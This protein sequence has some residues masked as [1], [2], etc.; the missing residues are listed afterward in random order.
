[1]IVYLITNKKTGKK[2]VGQTIK[3]LKRRWSL[4]LS[5]ATRGSAMYLHRAIRKYGEENFSVKPLH[6]CESREELNLSEVFY[7]SLLRTKSPKGYNMSD[8]GQGAVGTLQTEE[9]REKRSKAL[10]G[11]PWTSSRR[12]A[13]RLRPRRIPICHPKRK[14]KANGL[15][16]SC[17]YKNWAAENR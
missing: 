15:C 4:H 8:G 1:M 5:D 3:T 10:Q 16:R 13:D 11:K 7:I 17:A 9:S 2:Y 14:H 6:V 12:R